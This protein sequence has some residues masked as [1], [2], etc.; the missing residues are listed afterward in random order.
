MFTENS[1]VPE[2]EEA[3]DRVEEFGME[4][5]PFWT[6]ISRFVVMIGA[7]LVYWGIIGGF[8]MGVFSFVVG[9]EETIRSLEG[10]VFGVEMLVSS[11][12][13]YSDELFI[14]G[15][16]NYAFWIILKRE[17]LSLERPEYESDE[18]E[19]KSLVR[20]TVFSGILS[21]I[22]IGVSMGV[23][24]FPVAVPTI[25]FGLSYWVLAYKNARALNRTL[26][27]DHELESW[28]FMEMPWK[29]VAWSS[30]SYAL[31]VWAEGGLPIFS[32][33]QSQIFVVAVPIV[34]VIYLIRRAVGVKMSGDGMSKSKQREVLGPRSRSDGSKSDSAVNDDVSLAGD[35]SE[36]KY[37]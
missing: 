35:E 32:E 1:N 28:F 11:V 31:Y 27:E 15:L 5:F 3:R 10:V 16:V 33:V 2:G 13:S 20:W 24:S 25:V 36:W 9:F 4:R 21:M 19:W 34:S 22:Y 26:F 30:L 37:E 8:L 17:F 18:S 7:Q 29:F 12:Q 6:R 23:L 14:I